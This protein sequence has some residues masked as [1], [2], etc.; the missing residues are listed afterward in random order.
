M[1]RSPHDGVGIPELGAVAGVFGLSGEESADRLW[2][3]AGRGFTPPCR[4]GPHQ[5]FPQADPVCPRLRRGLPY[6]TAARIDRVAWLL[7]SG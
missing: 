6:R 7:F 2:R 3:S 1:G 5:L 4:C